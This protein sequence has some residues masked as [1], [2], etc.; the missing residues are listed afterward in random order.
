MRA[1]IDL[2]TTYSLASKIGPNGR[3]YLIPDVCQSGTFHTPSTVY[4]KGNTAFVG[5]TAELLLEQD[6]AMKV[7]RFF[8]RNLG[9]TEALYFDDQGRAWLPEAIAALVL[10]K[11]RYDVETYQPERLEGC[12]ITVPAHFNDIQRKAVQASAVYADITLLGLLEEPV[13]AAMHYGVSS[14]EEDQVILVYD[15]GGGTF[16]ATV[17]TFNKQGFYVLAK[18]GLTELGGKELDEAVAEIVLSQF[19]R[20]IG[21]PMSLGARGLLDLR[22]VSEARG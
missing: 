2:G 15:F 19:E 18:E 5:T 9:E 20:A 7:L 11:L 3:P 12:V 4:I 14:G 16:D 1:G 8:K 22:A 21:R 10:K 6:P 13:A 17:M